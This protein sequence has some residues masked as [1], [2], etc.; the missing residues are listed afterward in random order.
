MPTPTPIDDRPQRP[1]WRRRWF[2]ATGWRHVVGVLA[3][4][5]ALFPVWFVLIA[6]FSEDGSLSGQ[7]PA[8]GDVHARSSTDALVDNYPFW[9]WFV[10][11]LVISTVVAFGTVLLA[12][13]GR[14][15]LLPAAL[16]RPPGRPATRCC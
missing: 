2:A 6:A 16:P 9:R 7:T 5:F 1:G 4:F 15:R 3:L 11:S 12:A 14:L 13:L 8:A 10:N